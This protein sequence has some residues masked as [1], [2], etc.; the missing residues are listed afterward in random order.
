MSATPDQLPN[1][2]EEMK[3]LFLAQ[4]ANL[5]KLTAELTAASAEL[6]AA[7]DAHLSQEAHPGFSPGAYRTL[8]RSDFARD[9]TFG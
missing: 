9:T 7:K 1:D 5:E 6:A 8:I 4:A 2:I 3:R